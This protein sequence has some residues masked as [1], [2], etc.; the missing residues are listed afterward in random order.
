M[1]YAMYAFS[2]KALQSELSNSP[3]L[4]PEDDILSQR[5]II[6]TAQA[7]LDRM[8][9]SENLREVTWKPVRLSM[10][11]I[12]EPVKSTKDHSKPNGTH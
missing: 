11:S 4:M 8:T 5:G 10:K 12:I 6:A 2:W 7:I 9:N 1:R 3:Y